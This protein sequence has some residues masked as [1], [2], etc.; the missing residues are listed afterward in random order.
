MLRQKVRSNFSELLKFTKY[1]ELC[2]NDINL[3]I[4]NDFNKRHEVFY[5]T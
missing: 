5:P 1:T 2:L 4:R 3:Y